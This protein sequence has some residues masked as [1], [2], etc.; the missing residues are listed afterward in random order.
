MLGSLENVVN[1]GFDSRFET[2]DGL[3]L[4]A[5]P[6]GLIVA[7]HTLNPFAE[8]FDADL[9]AF[10]FD[11]TTKP[12]AG[13]MVGNNHCHELLLGHVI[14]LQPWSRQLLEQP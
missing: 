9:H 8:G 10:N 3:A 13:L 11:C 5:R 4:V 2:A 1:A 7:L 12:L 6:I 14:P